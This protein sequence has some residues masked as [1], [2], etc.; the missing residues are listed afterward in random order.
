M[1][2]ARELILVEIAMHEGIDFDVVCDACSWIENTTLLGLVARRYGQ[3]VSASSSERCGSLLGS[4]RKRS[5]LSQ[6]VQCEQS[7]WQ[8]C[9]AICFANRST[10][11]CDVF[12]VCRLADRVGHHRG[13]CGVDGLLVRGFRMDSSDGSPRRSAVASCDRNLAGDDALDVWLCRY[14]VNSRADVGRVQDV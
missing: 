2:Q 5:T 9:R 10:W 6:C 14:R 8:G 3:A 1:S 12:R 4:I 13:L 7:R 11:C